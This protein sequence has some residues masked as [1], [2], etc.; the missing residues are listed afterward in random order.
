MRKNRQI[1]L[2]AALLFSFLC[3]P[4]NRV[5]A[6]SNIVEVPLTVKQKFEVK[7]PEKET[8]L[9][10]SYEFRA[11]DTDAPMPEKSKEDV[12]SF[13]MEGE[14]ATHT[15]TLQYS[16][17]GVYHYQLVQTTKEKKNYQY[18]RSCY[19]I[20]VYVKSG[21]DGQLIPQ[22]IAKKGDGKKCGDLQFQN[23]CQGESQ[24]LSQSV[25]PN[26][27][28]TLSKPVKT[29]DTS[30]I[31]VYFAIA[32]GALAVIAALIYRKKYNWKKQ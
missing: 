29:G 10:G 5:F 30:N 31:V 3:F 9:T 20:M 21:E 2:L 15:I 22:V 32:L 13:S 18:D 1:I 11:S 28:G 6:K 26:T 16:D 25:N 7:N 19:D 4:V 8:D 17:T 12:Y 27:P 24:N 23:F 14:Q